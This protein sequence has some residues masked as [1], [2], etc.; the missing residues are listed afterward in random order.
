MMDEIAQRELVEKI[1]G[2]ISITTAQGILITNLLALVGELK[3][4]RLEALFHEKQKEVEIY[5][6]NGSQPE[7]KNALRVLRLARDLVEQGRI[8]IAEA[9][10]R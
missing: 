2:L 10:S 1:E 6:Q 3:P 9:E 7:M 8:Q 4:D 5:E